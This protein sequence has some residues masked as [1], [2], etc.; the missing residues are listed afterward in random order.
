MKKMKRNDILEPK[1][2]PKPVEEVVIKPVVKPVVKPVSRWFFQSKSDPV[3]K[4]ELVASQ[5]QV[6]TRIEA[7]ATFTQALAQEIVK[8]LSSIGQLT[9]RPFRRGVGVEKKQKPP[10]LGDDPVLVDTSILI[11]GRIV[12]VVNSGFFNGTLIIPKFV[13]EEVQHIADSADIVR[14]TKGRRG[15]D[16]VS[17][18]KSQKTNLHVKVKIV[19]DDPTDVKEVDHKLIA[20]IKKWKSAP[21]GKELRLL[22]VDFNL[23]QLARAQSVKVLNVNDLAQAIKIAL[24]PGEE[25]NLKITHIGKEREQGVG[26]LDDGTMVV[27]DNA[28]DKVGQDITAIIIKI[29]QT[30]A[31]QLFFGRLK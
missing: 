4:T 24:V 15:L 6:P 11:D 10:I 26:Y 27:V 14:R 29:H 28:K 13:M 8:N 12:P 22:T 17:K 25:L 2:E 9:T 19:S 20:L 31:G 7:T 18:L 1:S 3:G 5:G 21:G 23:A 16:V 30:P